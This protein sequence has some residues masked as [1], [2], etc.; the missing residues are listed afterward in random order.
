MASPHLIGVTGLAINAALAVTIVLWPSRRFDSHRVL[1]IRIIVVVSSVISAGIAIALVLTM[2]S[3]DSGHFAQYLSPESWAW[4]GLAS[5]ASHLLLLRMPSLLVLRIRDEG[6]ARAALALTQL[7]DMYSDPR[8]DSNLIASIDSLTN[9][10][11]REL[12]SY[13]LTNDLSLIKHEVESGSDERWTTAPEVARAIHSCLLRIADDT[14]SVFSDFDQV[15]QIAGLGV[16][17]TLV[18]SVGAR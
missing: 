9:V 18:A 17:L 1:P 2:P 16:L 3:D 10:Y 8:D 11:E 12:S 7:L 6:F 14:R 13:N 15:F 5:L 4:I